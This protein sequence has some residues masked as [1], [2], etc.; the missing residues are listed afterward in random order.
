[1]RGLLLG[2]LV[3]AAA[4]PA[5]AASGSATPPGARG[6]VLFSQPRCPLWAGRRC[7]AR[8]QP[9]AVDPASGA[10]FVPALAAADAVPSPDGSSV[11][12]ETG[13]DLLVAAADGSGQ[14]P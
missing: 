12:W 1:M 8:D 2:V 7:I 3:C 13:T 10:A 9:C 11:A 14:R 4:A 6:L 5:T